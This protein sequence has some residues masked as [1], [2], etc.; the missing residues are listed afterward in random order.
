MP[1]ATTL[2]KPK[3]K[4]NRTPSDMITQAITSGSDLQKLEKLLELQERWGANEARKAYHQAMAAFKANPPEIEKDKKVSFG[5][6]K[7]NHATL[8]NVTKKINHALSVHGFSVSWIVKQNG[9]V[10]VTCKITHE[11]GRAWAILSQLRTW[12][13]KRLSRK[14][15]KVSEGDFV[16]IIKR[17]GDF[18]K[19]ETPR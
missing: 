16:E 17:I 3:R 2:K 1:I 7:Y 19:I 18:L 12:S 5:T 10:S 15:G 11:Q 6:T 14:I 4:T 8:A 13:S 9:S